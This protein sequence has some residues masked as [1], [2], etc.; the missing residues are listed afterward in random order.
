M[1]VYNDEIQRRTIEASKKINDS[2]KEKKE[3]GTLNKHDML[4][5]E[6]ARIMEMAFSDVFGYNERFRNPW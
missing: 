3:N 2:I 5:L 4:K 1:R 6:E